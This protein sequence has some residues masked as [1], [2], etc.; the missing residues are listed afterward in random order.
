MMID[1]GERMREQDENKLE[2]EENL[3]PNM[4]TGETLEESE[5]HEDQEFEDIEDS[6]EDSLEEEIMFLKKENR[7]LGDENKKLDNELESLKER[8][9]RTSAE[10]ENFRKRTAKEKEGIYTD[11]CE[12][13][14]K[15]MLP[16]LDNLERAVA[17]EGGMEDIK[18]GIEMTIRQFQSSLERLQVEEIDS[19]GEFNPHLHNAVM[20]IEDESYGKNEIVEVFQ[21]GYK[22]GD[23]V[24]RYSMVK[25]AN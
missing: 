24:L 12:D 11:A 10:Y 4:D 18:K 8:L 2:K 20:H 14:L 23:K 19:K 16:V 17:V 5:V 15:T 22:R 7:N 21:K 13:V 9:V 6:E 3:D 25:V 1:R